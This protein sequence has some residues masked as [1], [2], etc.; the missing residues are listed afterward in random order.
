MSKCSNDNLEQFDEIKTTKISAVSE[1]ITPKIE[2]EV[3][4]NENYSFSI[5]YPSGWTK[6][7]NGNSVAFVDKK[8]KT[9]MTVSFD[10]YAPQVNTMTAGNIV[11]IQENTEIIDFTKSNDCYVTTYN[12]DGYLVCE[13][14]LW[15]Y[16]N[17]ISI[18]IIG[19][20]NASDL[21]EYKYLLSTV[22]WECESPIPDGLYIQY[23][24]YG[25]FQ[26]GIP[27]DWSYGVS[28]NSILFSN[29][30]DT[31]NVNLI[32]EENNGNLSTVSQ[33]DYLISLAENRNNFVCDYYTNDENIIYSKGTYDFNG[34]QAVVIRYV[35]ASGEY[36]YMLTIDYIASDNTLQSTLEDIINSFTVFD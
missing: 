27:E 32:I 13:G 28:D 15:D 4:Y 25:N 7:D 16:Q 3:Y 2:T 12:K 31:A 11:N 21:S 20:E 9:T 24:E 35:Y 33:T 26:I 5:N 22:N 34:E 23:Y 30:N 14:V 1:N 19:D 36:F 17:I 29:P 18:Y 6:A 10:E 8:T